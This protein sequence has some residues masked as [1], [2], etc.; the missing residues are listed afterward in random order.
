MSVEMPIEL[1]KKQHAKYFQRFLHMVPGQLA[2]FDFTRLMFAFF[3]ISGLDMLDALDDLSP[4]R[5]IEA[6]EWI[7]RLQIEDAGP[8]S[9]FQSSTTLP[10]E[11]AEYQCGHLAMTYTGLATLLV[12]GDDLRRVN[13]KSIIEGIQACQNPD[14]SFTAVVA[15]YESDMRFLYC[16]CCVSAILDD[17]SG[18]NKPAAINYIVQS[19]SYDGGIGQGPGLESHGGSTFCAVASLFLMNELDNILCNERLNRLS[20]WIGAT[21]RLLGVGELSDSEKNRTFLLDT[22]DTSTGGFSKFKFAEPDPMHTYLGLCGL[23]LIGEPGL[24]EMYAAL[25]ISQRA[26]A[27]L[28]DIH[29]RWRNE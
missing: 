12:L 6:I 13:R 5:K 17:W 9:G 27:Q 4:D 23:S 2:S 22:Q 7:Y 11:V 28:R 8:R 29:K 16:A 3:A 24:Q 26:Y 14:G 1:V 20:F 15:G 18:I 25:N 19:I 21:L 10:K